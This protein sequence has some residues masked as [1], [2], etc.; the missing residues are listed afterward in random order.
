MCMCVCVYYCA[1]VFNT[2]LQ[3]YQYSGARCW[4][5]SLL[6]QRGREST[7]LTFLLSQHPKRERKPSLSTAPQK[8]FKLNVSPF[9]S[10]VSLPVL[11]TSSHSLWLSCLLVAC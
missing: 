1:A 11:L 3:F 7:V 5:E 8:P 4:G 9:Y 6:A 2:I 10:R